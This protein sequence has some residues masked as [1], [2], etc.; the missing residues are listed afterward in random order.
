MAAHANVCKQLHLPAQSGSSGVLERM[1][2][3]YDRDAYLTLAA[4][5]RE[6]L[7]GVA[8]SSDFIA[9]FCG[10]TEAEHADTLSL[11]HEVRYEHAFMFAYS[12]RDKTSAARHLADDVPPD[13]KQRRLEEVRWARRTRGGAR[14]AA[15]R[16]AAAAAARRR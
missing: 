8:L 11:M 3:G 13:V 7:P 14:A 10:E 6:A 15:E 5:A 2:R 9:G 12:R 4:H 1:R 16:S